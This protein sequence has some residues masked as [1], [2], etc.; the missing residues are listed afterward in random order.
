WTEG[1]AKIGAPNYTEALNA[2]PLPCKYCPLGC[3][4]QIKIEDP[5]E[6]AMEGIGP[7]YETL[8]MLG[9]NCLIDDPKAIAVGND[10]C[11]RLGIDTISA[12]ACIAFAMEC[13]EKGWLTK[14]Q[15]GGLELEW[16]DTPVMIELLKQIGNRDGFGAIF[17]GG[18]LKAAAKIHPDSV[19]RVAHCKGLDFAAHDPRTNFSLAINC[20][21]GTR[22]ACHMRGMSGDVE[23]GGFFIPELGITTETSEMFNDENKALLAIK[24]QDFAALLN[25]LV[26]CA[27]MVD[28]A[29]MPFQAVMD[30]F[31][32]I[33]GWK[34]SIED[35]T[36]AGARVFTAQRL[37]N[38]R[39]GFDAK[40][41]NLPK[42]MFEAAKEGFRTGK[43]PNFQVYLKD[44]YLIRGWN[45][46]GYVTQPV[47]D[48]L[49][50]SAYYVDP[51][52]WAE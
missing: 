2:K 5:E 42:V 7:E 33:T 18:A 51:G 41:D 26:L 30:M 28:G 17:A 43:V 45:E 48:E 20:A 14:D 29:E 35:F 40:T 10:I 39:D 50:L 12:G 38:L 22:G 4:R 13:Y 1:A 44:Y 16:G 31:N 21:T 49:G 46:N 25:S 15:T 19:E 32:A 23:M 3:H 11:N 52:N 8:G 9:S 47:L 27:F 6:Y 36:K 24:L 37:I 34:F